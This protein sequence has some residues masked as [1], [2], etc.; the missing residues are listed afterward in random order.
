MSFYDSNV[1][2]VVLV[3]EWFPS[4]EWRIGM[5]VEVVHCNLPTSPSC[6][7]RELLR[8]HRLKACTRVM[9]Q[10]RVHSVQ[11]HSVQFS[12]VRVQHMLDIKCPSRL[13]VIVSSFKLSPH[14][15][16][17]STPIKWTFEYTYEYKTENAIK[18]NL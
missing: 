17:D 11:H 1:Q 6:I 2:F 16:T 13:T 3:V 5:I 4:S 8:R 10:T 15:T 7:I 12:S 9:L 18:C 14:H